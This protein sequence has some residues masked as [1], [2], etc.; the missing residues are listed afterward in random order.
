MAENS[1]SISGSALS[2]LE[3]KR[4]IPNRNSER[5]ITIHFSNARGAQSAP[6]DDS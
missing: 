1:G 6:T 2:W 5:S 4:M 3:K